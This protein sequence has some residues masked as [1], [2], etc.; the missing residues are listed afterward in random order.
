MA[1]TARIQKN[2]ENTSSCEAN[3]SV[4]LPKKT[5]QAYQMYLWSQLPQQLIKN[6]TNVIIIIIIILLILMNSTP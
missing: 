1:T 4:V 5:V 6:T 2:N 3:A